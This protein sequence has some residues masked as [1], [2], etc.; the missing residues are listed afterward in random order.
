MKSELVSTRSTPSISLPT[1]M[2]SALMSEQALSSSHDFTGDL[3][4]RRLFS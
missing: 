4:I 2:I 1:A 3:K